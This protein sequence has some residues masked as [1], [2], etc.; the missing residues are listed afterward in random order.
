MPNKSKKR[1]PGVGLQR[2]VSRRRAEGLG[3]L[4]MALAL[5]GMPAD[6][7]PP[8]FP[9]VAAP[10][11]PEPPCPRCDSRRTRPP[12]DH[13]SQRRC[14]DCGHRFAAAG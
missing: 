12:M 13:E 2:K 4:G 8:G 3:M 7:K 6:M 11:P 10:P 1:R 9:K 14:R 5:S